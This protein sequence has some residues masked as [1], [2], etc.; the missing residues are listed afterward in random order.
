MIASIL[1]FR[2]YVSLIGVSIA[3]AL[4]SNL[5]Q[6]LFAK[7]FIFGESVMY[8]APPL[9]IMGFVSA[10]ILGLLASSFI[11]RSTWLDSRI[12]T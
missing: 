12:E 4:A 3:G 8:I 1:L 5:V 10:L 6:L 11:N 7:L 9:L 2:S